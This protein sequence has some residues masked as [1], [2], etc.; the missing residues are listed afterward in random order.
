MKASYAFV[1][2]VYNFGRLPK[3]REGCARTQTPS[4]LWRPLL[5]PE[6]LAGE[7][8]AEDQ[9]HACQ[10]LEGTKQQGCDDVGQP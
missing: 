3:K 2:P 4:D 7:T 5:A 10:D 8:A 9:S 1:K 6:A